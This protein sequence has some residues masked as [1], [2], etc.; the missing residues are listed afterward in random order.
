M[1][2]VHHKPQT[3]QITKN[4]HNNQRVSHSLA[5]YESNFVFFLGYKSIELKMFIF[6]VKCV[7]MMLYV[8][9]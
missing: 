1:A 2:L 6:V 7:K 4:I 5:F 3:K 8:M 9:K